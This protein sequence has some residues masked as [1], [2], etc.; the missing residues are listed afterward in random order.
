[1]EYMMSE[2]RVMTGPKRTRRKETWNERGSERGCLYERAGRE[3]TEE[4]VK[5]S[6]WQR[7]VL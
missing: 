6:E 3:R 7:A 4:R 2:G 5:A 1:M